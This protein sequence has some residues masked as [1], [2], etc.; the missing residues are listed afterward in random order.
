M[1]WNGIDPKALPV[2]AMESVRLFHRAETEAPVKEPP[3]TTVLTSA[4]PTAT[5]KPV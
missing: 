2:A 3:R 4:A 1:V 5:A